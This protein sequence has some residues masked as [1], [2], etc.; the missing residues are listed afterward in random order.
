MITNLFKLYFILFPLGAVGYHYRGNF[1]V[2]PA[3]LLV[4]LISILTIITIFSQ[5]IERKSITSMQSIMLILILYIFITTI[6]Q[7]N[8][9]SF[10]LSLFTFVILLIPFLLIDRI[11]DFNYYKYY[12]YGVNLMMAFVCWELVALFTGIP[13][14]DDLFPYLMSRSIYISSGLYRISGPM[15]EASTLGAYCIFSLVIISENERTKKRMIYILLLMLI[16]IISQS[17]AAI[18][19]L[20]VYISYKL[21]FY[22]NKQIIP[23]KTILLPICLVILLSIKFVPRIYSYQINRIN[24]M[25]NYSIINDTSS[26][27]SRRI[28]SLIVGVNYFMDFPN[29]IIG[30]G[31]ANHD[32][33]I[34]NKYEPFIKSGIID[35]TGNINNAISA[36]I[37]STGLIGLSLMYLIIYKLWLKSE[38]NFKLFYIILW[39]IYLFMSGDIVFHYFW[40]Y[41]YILLFKIPEE[42]YFLGNS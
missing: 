22:L 11:K 4:G 24:K 20:F 31:F 39:V 8:L 28:F 6:L 27:I 38:V 42:K 12:L 2:T 23:V 10:A 26:S 9:L 7:N 14:F 34:I 18:I 41:L 19:M 5:I 13:Y 3:L 32:R 35:E 15:P 40:G 30:V 21:L 29:S 17:T 33:Y 25:L 1:H 36:L 16:V 37:I